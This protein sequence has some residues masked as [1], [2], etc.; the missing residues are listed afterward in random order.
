MTK[1]IAVNMSHKRQLVIRKQA[2]KEE[3][4]KKTRR[5]NNIY[6]TK[7]CQLLVHEHDR[8]YKRQMKLN[9]GKKYL[10]KIYCFFLFFYLIFQ[11]LRQL[12]RANG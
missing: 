10:R 3:A 12:K 1:F 8:Q 2:K 11:K 9:K 7:Q 4:E 5:R 6:K